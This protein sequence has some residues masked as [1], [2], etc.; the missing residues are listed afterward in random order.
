ML[1]FQ[2]AVK[3]CLQCLL[4]PLIAVIPRK[5][6]NTWKSFISNG[7]LSYINKWLWHISFMSTTTEI[8]KGT[9]E[10]LRYLPSLTELGSFLE[11]ELFLLFLRKKNRF[12]KFRL[13]SLIHLPLLLLSPKLFSFLQCIDLRPTECLIGLFLYHGNTGILHL[14]IQHLWEKFYTDV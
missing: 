3:D 6:E 14:Y 11:M 7:L 9:V 4:T 13:V 12:S 2:G 8:Q 1:T 10:T 5:Q